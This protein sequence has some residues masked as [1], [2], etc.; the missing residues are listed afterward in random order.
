MSAPNTSV[1]TGPPKEAWTSLND[2]DGSGNLTYSGL[3]RSTQA[4]FTFAGATVSKANPGVVGYTAHGMTS[5]QPV[6]IAG[7]SGDWAALNGARIATVTGANTFTI[8]VDTSGYSGSFD[9]TVSTTAPR[10]NAT[11]WA[12]S[13]NYFNGSSQLTRSAW[14]N[15]N[16]SE[17]YAWDS[18]STYAF[19]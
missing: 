14:C 15:S 8:G 4:A 7:A 5:G 19:A 11:C 1:S 12:I 17:I 10:T 16:P 9:G 18:R 2:Y 3:A 6:L 13:Q